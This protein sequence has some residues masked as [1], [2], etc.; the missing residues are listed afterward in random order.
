MRSWNSFRI[1]RDG[2]LNINLVTGFKPHNNISFVAPL[3]LHFFFLFDLFSTKG[4]FVLLFRII[5]QT[6]I[7]CL[8]KAYSMVADFLGI[9][10]F[11]FQMLA[12]SA[13]T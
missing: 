6:L 1:K 2:S 12:S 13:L 8:G 7:W 11:H 3:F 10:R 9:S 5:N 4:C